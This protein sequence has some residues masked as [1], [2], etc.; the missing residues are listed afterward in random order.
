MRFILLFLIGLY[1]CC[2]CI[3]D[4]S[5]RLFSSAASH[6]TLTWKAFLNWQCIRPDTLSNGLEHA[7]SSGN[8]AVKRFKMDRKG[9][10][11]V[12]FSAF[13]TSSLLICPCETSLYTCCHHQANSVEGL[14]YKCSSNSRL[15]LFIFLGTRDIIIVHWTLLICYWLSH[16]PRL[17]GYVVVLLLHLKS[18]MR[19]SHIKWDQV[20]M[21]QGADHV[22]MGMRL[23]WWSHVLLLFEWRDTAIVFEQVVSRL[24]FIAALGHMTRI[25]SQF[26][27]T[28]KVSGP[29]ALQPSQVMS[30]A[31]LIVFWTC[32]QCIL[33]GRLNTRIEKV[34]PVI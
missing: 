26:E 2:V 21:L 33:G 23:C 11:Q 6:Y 12:N 18:W 25:S 1:A 10:T 34:V 20:F 8:W 29:R 3:W 16:H 24:S 17:K 9:V 31:K 4:W 28:R 22:F 7:I 13:S 19:S 32:E 15:I 27:K 30:C 14:V 5:W